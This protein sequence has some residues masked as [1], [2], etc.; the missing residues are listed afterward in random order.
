MKETQLQINLPGVPKAKQGR[1]VPPHWEWTEASVWTERM[2]AALERGV[3]GSQWFSLM[4]KVWKMENLQSA[5][6]QVRRKQGGAG[7]D[8]QSCEDYL[9]ASPQR[10]PRL[11]AQLKNGSYRPQPVKR[12]WIPKLGSQELRPLGVPTVEDRVVQSALRH[13]LE[14]IFERTFADHSYGFR[15]GRGAKQALRR[16]DQLLKTGHRW[17]VDA[18]LKGYFDSI[19]QDK[20]MA[21]VEAQIADGAVL[22]LIEQLLGQGVMESGK[23]WQPTETGTPQGA[24]ISPLLANIYLNPLDQLMAGQGRQMVRYADDFVILCQN[25]Q[26]AQEVLEQLRQWTQAAGLT[27]HPA[28]TRIVD[29]SQKGGFDFLGYHFER[30]YRWPRQKSLDKLKATIREKTCSGRPGSLRDIIR[31]INHCTRGWFEYFKHSQNTVFRPL[32]SWIRQ[33]LRRLLRRRHTGSRR[34]ACRDHQRWPVSYFA[35]LGLI[36]LALA[37]EQASHAPSGAH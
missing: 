34:A 9:R 37:R 24:V 2:L 23:G 12:V 35:K 28:K 14:P 31:E 10:L 20:L 17:V 16:V 25:Q 19:P 32:D 6:Q 1:E 13:V 27:L 36:S 15:P 22:K 7:V 4:D 26:Q 3:K 11:Q 33:R 30:D 18:D 8:G 21:A 5:L 29:A